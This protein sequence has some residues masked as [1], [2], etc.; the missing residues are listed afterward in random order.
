MYIELKI[1][2]LNDSEDEDNENNDSESE[3]NDNIITIKQI[4]DNIKLHFKDIKNISYG[5]INNIE[6][7]QYS[8][9]IDE[10]NEEGKKNVEIKNKLRDIKKFLNSNKSN[11]K[12]KTNMTIHCSNIKTFE[13][14]IIFIKYDA[15]NM[16]YLYLC[17]NCFTSWKNK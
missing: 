9:F 2:D 10:D 8:L 15:T 4:I 7:N 1:E 17:T 5:R 14:D 11:I 16:K 3:E 12:K 6:S 13:N